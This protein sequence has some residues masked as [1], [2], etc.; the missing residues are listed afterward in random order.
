MENVTTTPTATRK[1]AYHT[2]EEGLLLMQL[3][4]ARIENG[5]NPKQV[6]TSLGISTI[7]WVDIEA[8]RGI[9]NLEERA[10]ELR[11]LNNERVNKLRVK[12]AEINAAMEGSDQTLF[13]QAITICIDA[14]KRNAM[15]FQIAAMTMAQLV[16]TSDKPYVESAKDAV[17]AADCLLEELLNA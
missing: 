4:I 13:D 17:L 12:K 5:E 14:E 1:R 2:P 15:R 9:T 8:T 7:R 6:T 3:A 11:R 10:R 16:A